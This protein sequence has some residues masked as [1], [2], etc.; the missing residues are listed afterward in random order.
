MLLLRSALVCAASV[1]S[2]AA[3]AA[4]PTPLGSPASIGVI[5]PALRDAVRATWEASP[6][7]QAARAERDAASARARAADQPLYNPTLSVDAENADVDRRT[8]GLG[9][10]LDLSGKRRARTAEGQA[11]LRASEASFEIARRDVAL[12]WLRTWSA[13]AL[14]AQQSEFGKRRV[15]LMRRFDDLAAQRLSVGDISSPERDLAGLALGEAHIQQATLVSTEA[16]LRA[17]LLAI[18]GDE[19]VA[20]PPLPVAPPPNS[21]AIMPRAA[22]DLPELREARARVERSDAAID[23]ARRN[24]IPDPTVSL[25][26]G[27]VR[28]GPFNDRVTD[29]VIGLS[30]SIPLPV[31]NTGRAEVDAARADADAAAAGLRTRELTLRAGQRETRA[32]YDALRDAV[33]SFRGGRAAA[34]DDRTALLEKLWRAG[35][36][37]TSD[38]LVQLKQ[39]LDTALSGLDLE[40]RTWQAWF[41]YLAAT[42]HLTDWIEGTTQQD[43]SP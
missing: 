41:D 18:A 15:E 16:S 39:S 23:V 19:G 33:V 11:Q 3:F 8:A 37:S 43:A 22:Q 2:V 1:F 20:L 35:E 36:I 10:T 12:R 29:R 14:A 17:S 31:L 21:Q 34:L 26:G 42:G 13:A 32:R 4:S 28:S 9:L 27:Q 5:S 24:R 30:V 25:I 38:F 6:E 7:V 40:S